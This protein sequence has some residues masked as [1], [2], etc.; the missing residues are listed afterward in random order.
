MLWIVNDTG[1]IT[2]IYLYTGVKDCPLTSGIDSWPRCSYKSNWTSSNGDRTSVKRPPRQRHCLVMVTLRSARLQ[3]FSEFNYFPTS[4]NCD[5]VTRRIA[6][7]SR[8]AET[9]QRT[10]F[11]VSLVCVVHSLEF[12][13]RAATA[14]ILCASALSSYIVSLRVAIEAVVTSWDGRPRWRSNGQ[15]V[16]SCAA[17]VSFSL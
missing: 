5:F 7:G 11:F 6:P 8:E 9:S 16:N 2:C 17:A 15:H 4:F 10:S 3:V 1:L 13:R 12:R 14:S